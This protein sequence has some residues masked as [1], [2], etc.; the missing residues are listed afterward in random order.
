[1]TQWPLAR[2]FPSAR[3]R[4]AVAL[5]A[6]DMIQMAKLFPRLLRFWIA[7][8]TLL[9][10]CHR[11]SVDGVRFLPQVDWP[12]DRLLGVDQATDSFL[13]SCHWDFS[14]TWTNTSAYRV[15]V[16]CGRWERWGK[17]T[18]YVL[19]LGSDG[20]VVDY[21]YTFAMAH[22][23]PRLLISASPFRVGFSAKDTERIRETVGLSGSTEEWRTRLSQ[24]VELERKLREKR[25][26]R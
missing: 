16:S 22:S 19:V 11:T 6:Y 13:R 26:K 12:L 3:C 1:M 9:C 24:R 15:F 21:N 14:A 17:E 23:V 4:A 5:A 7:L 8:A 20:Q 18:W 10:S 2:F 25:E